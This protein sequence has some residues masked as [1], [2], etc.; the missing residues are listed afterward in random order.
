MSKI[1]KIPFLPHI[2]K[3]ILVHYKVEEPLP[4]PAKLNNLLGKIIN[5]VLIGEKE[6]QKANDRCTTHL[7]MEFGKRLAERELRISKLMLLNRYFDKMFKDHMVQWI[8]AQTDLGITEM[9][10]IRRFLNFYKITEDEYSL[11]IAHRQ[12]MRHKNGE[13]LRTKST[14]ADCAP[15]TS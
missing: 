8:L 12:W 15:L 14:A 1:V 10:A 3:F 6:V 13:Y 11:L 7:T 5:A 9:E 4:V 2:K